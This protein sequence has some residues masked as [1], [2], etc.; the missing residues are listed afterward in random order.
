MVLISHT[1]KLVFIHIPKT[2]GSYV[3]KILMNIDPEFLQIS[4]AEY[5][6]HPFY[7]I[8]DLEIYE[9]IKDYTFFCTVR[10]PFDLLLSHYNY[11]LTCK[12]SYYL[13]NDI[14][15]KSFNESI[16]LLLEHNTELNL[17]YIKENV[18]EYNEINNPI[19]KDIVILNFHN[20]KDDLINFL[21]DFKIS[22]DILNEIDFSEKVN[23]S[24]IFTKLKDI[25]TEYFLKTNYSLRKVV[26]DNKILFKNHE[27]FK[28]HPIKGIL[29]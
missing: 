7:K 11:I 12:E 4:N 3:K 6:H 2:G 15:N 17:R 19:N 5:G 29:L 16:D 9:K 25:D 10:E 1:Y 18:D 21:L 14:N 8:K 26:E 22:K 28:P 27:D 24:N 13:Y 23:C 20:I